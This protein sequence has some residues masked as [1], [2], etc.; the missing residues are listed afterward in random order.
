MGKAREV[1]LQIMGKFVFSNNLNEFI[2]PLWLVE[3]KIEEKE[4][5]TM[6]IVVSY[7]VLVS[8]L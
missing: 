5:K 6:R 2:H 3:E 1:Q 7:V 8:K 4:R